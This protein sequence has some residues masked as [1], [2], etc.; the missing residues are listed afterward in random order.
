M[1]LDHLNGFSWRDLDGL[2]Q[3]VGTDTSVVEGM[4]QSPDYD[5]DQGPQVG[6]DVNGLGWYDNSMSHNPIIL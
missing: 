2:G 3:F 5:L 4:L 6:Q 1:D